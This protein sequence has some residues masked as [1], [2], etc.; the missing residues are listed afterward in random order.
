[1]SAVPEE[2]AGDGDGNWVHEE[3]V[4]VLVIREDRADIDWNSD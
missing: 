3:T 4:H 1:M 2:G